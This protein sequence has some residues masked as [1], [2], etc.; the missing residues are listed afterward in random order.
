MLIA[1]IASI[2]PMEMGWYPVCMVHAHPTD[3][4]CMHFVLKTAFRQPVCANL[5]L[6]TFTRGVYVPARQ[7]RRRMPSAPRQ[8]RAGWSGRCPRRRLHSGTDP[9]CS[10]WEC[11]VGPASDIPG[12]KDQ[13]TG[14][15][16]YSN[17][18]NAS[19]CRPGN[20]GQFHR[21]A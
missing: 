21:A 20:R 16:L 19:I 2:T 8:L 13:S 15:S 12:H 1:D 4:L 11:S 6:V 18:N 10:P 14:R 9:E 17:N 3:A 7:H 5:Q